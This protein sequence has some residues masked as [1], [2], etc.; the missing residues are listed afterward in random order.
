MKKSSL[1][2]GLIASSLLLSTSLFANVEMNIVNFEKKRLSKNPNVKIEDIKVFDTKKLG[3]SNWTGYILNIKG[4]VQGKDIEVKDILFSDGEVIAT[5]LYD[6]GTGK[7]LKPLVTPDI[8]ENYYKK[9]KLIAG[10]HNGK[11]KMVVFSDPLCPFCM[12][13]I[14]EIVELVNKNKEDIALYYYHYPLVQSHP[15]AVVLSKIMHIAHTK[16]VENIEYKVYKADWD[17]YFT[18]QETN[19]VKIL[20]AFNEEFQTDIKL[21]ELMDKKVEMEVANDMKMGNDLMITGTP[22]VYVNGKKDINRD[23]FKKFEK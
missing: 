23:F 22:T 7:A 3:Q 6:L 18:S 10:N 8:T 11:N 17:E 5:D 1:L 9:E 12:D 21:D 2:S 19:A 14:P 15:A 4:Q 20:N 16:N 13:L